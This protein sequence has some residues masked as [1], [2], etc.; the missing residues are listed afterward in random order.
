MKESKPS[1]VI[2][3]AKTVDQLRAISQ[4]RKSNQNLAWSQQNI[5]IEIVNATYKKECKNA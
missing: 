1:T 2:M 3:P 5:I 4:T